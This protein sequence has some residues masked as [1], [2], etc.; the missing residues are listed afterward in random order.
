MKTHT[1]IRLSSLHKVVLV[2][3]VHHISANYYN[4]MMTPEFICDSTEII[5]MTLRARDVLETQRNR[6]M[7]ILSE[8]GKTRPTNTPSEST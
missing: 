4:K 8:I 5:S 2:I 1:R 6:R 7:S 3:G